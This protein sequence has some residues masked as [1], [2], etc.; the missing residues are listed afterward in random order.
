MWRGAADLVIEPDVAGFAYD[1]FKRADELVRVG[2]V[3]MRKALPAVRAWLDSA[4]QDTAASKAG[5][6]VA[7][8]APMPAD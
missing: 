3:A 5:P 4:V 6:V 1:D 2:E 8:P 7:K